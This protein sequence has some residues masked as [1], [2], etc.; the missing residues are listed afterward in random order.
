[1][2]QNDYGHAAVKLNGNPRAHAAPE[3]QADRAPGGPPC[4]RCKGRGS[5]C[6]VHSHI[7][8]DVAAGG[9]PHFFI[10]DESDDPQDDDEAEGSLEDDQLEIELYL[11][12]VN[13]CSANAMRAFEA[14]EAEARPEE[15]D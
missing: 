2:K 15:E 6:K 1:M 12:A 4:G 3:L 13:A 9:T 10:G 5:T 14:D 11:A 8:A 7:E